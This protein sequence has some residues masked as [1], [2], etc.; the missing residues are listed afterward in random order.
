MNY[1]HILQMFLS[2]KKYLLHFLKMTCS[3]LLTSLSAIELKKSNFLVSLAGKKHYFN[4]LLRHLT[5]VHF[6]IKNYSFLLFC[7]IPS[8]NI[9]T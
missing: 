6:V 4:T 5:T 9:L 7:N 3:N 2:F 1:C 8:P